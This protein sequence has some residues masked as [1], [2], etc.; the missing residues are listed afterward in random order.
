MTTPAFSI[1][2]PSRDR[3][4]LLSYA[5]ESVRR[6]SVGDFEIIVSDNAS[7]TPYEELVMGLHDERLLYLRVDPGV[8]V[9]ENW[10]RALSQAR[11]QYVV[12]LGDDDAL[13]PG[14]LETM[15][16]TIAAFDRPD[17][18]YC[19]AYQYWYP[20]VTPAEPSGYLAI[21]RNSP[22]LLGRSE[23]YRLPHTQAVALAK[24]G[25]A[26]HQDF[27]FNSQHL[28]WRRDTMPAIAK[29]GEFFK[30]PYPDFYSSIMTF[31]NAEHIVVNPR[32]LVIIGVS[33]K[34]FGFYFHA[35]DER[36]GAAFLGHDMAA[37]RPDDPEVLP[38]SDHNTKWLLAAREVVAS[39]AGAKD[40][41]VGIGNYRRLQV[42]ESVRR[43][44]VAGDGAS[45]EAL[46]HRL[47]LGE[48]VLARA[49]QASLRAVRWNRPQSQGA[50]VLGIVN[51]ALD[52]HFPAVI[53]RLPIGR[54]RNVLDALAWLDGGSATD[55]AEEPSAATVAPTPGIY[56]NPYLGAGQQQVLD[57]FHDL[58]YSLPSEGEGVGTI[59]LSWLGTELFKC[60]M[61]LWLYQELIHSTRPDVIVETGTYRGG[62]AHY[63]ATVCDLVGHGGVVTIDVS[64]WSDKPRP[65]HP[66]LTYLVGSSTDPMVLDKVS[67]LV[68]KNKK[69]LVILDSDH[70]REHVLAELRLYQGFVPV[71]G[72]MIVED[73][74]VNGHPTF[75]DHGPGPW[76]A[77]DDFL[78]ES[79][80][81]VADRTLER[82][83]LTMN[84]RGYLRRVGRTE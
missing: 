66:R 21:V 59:L 54:H 80:D 73:T 37:A 13:A 5:I 57:R 15:A 17:A 14:Y 74:N 2:L 45:L 76:E 16:E 65:Q 3:P 62:S 28:L 55:D 56:A 11:G 38:G 68:G 60:P 6:Q 51:R 24:R 7:T 4:E 83:L 44:V 35:G 47:Q 67:A 81:F 77:V 46:R 52:Q 29:G 19:A 9:T 22:L 33:P 36:G 34:S 61:D 64:P 63:L 71:G 72:L 1:L 30:S 49:L 78:R 27:G 84:P 79:T 31:L 43:A 48:I 26:F 25:L 41:P 20:G 82:F 8:S 69:V 53:T 50:F 75:R 12:M 42:V 39:E 23:P 10:N 18:V 58:Y 70:A 40:L 32:P